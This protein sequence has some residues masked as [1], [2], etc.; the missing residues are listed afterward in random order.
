MQGPKGQLSP[1]IALVL[2]PL[3]SKL[4]RGAEGQINGSDLNCSWD[5]SPNIISPT[6]GDA[7]YFIEIDNCNLHMRETYHASEFEMVVWLSFIIQ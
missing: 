5:F 2:S 4:S 1:V 6:T 3:G 7:G